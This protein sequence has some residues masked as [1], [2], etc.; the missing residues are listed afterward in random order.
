MCPEMRELEKQ[1]DCAIRKRDAYREALLVAN[2]RR[3]RLAR[4]LARERAEADAED[5]AVG[6]FNTFHEMTVAALTKRAEQ[7]EKERDE[8]R[9][10][11][12]ALRVGA[13]EALG[14]VVLPACPDDAEIIG[15]AGRVKQRAEF[16]PSVT[17]EAMRH[18]EIA[19]LNKKLAEATTSLEAASKRLCEGRACTECGRRRG[20]FGGLCP[21]CDCVEHNEGPCAAE[22]RGCRPAIDLSDC[23]HCRRPKDRGKEWARHG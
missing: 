19:D 13:C 3:R 8:A 23:K 9:A 5:V 1:R 2:R 17:R 18:T 15:A 21:N 12:S 7:A 16:S 4:D 22:C 14:L 20:E 10:E 11:T 6:A